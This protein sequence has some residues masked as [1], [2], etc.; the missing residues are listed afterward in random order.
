MPSSSMVDHLLQSLHTVFPSI[1]RLGLGH[2]VRSYLQ[3]SK[4]SLLEFLDD[5]PHARHRKDLDVH[6]CPPKL[7]AELVPPW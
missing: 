4:Q 1:L 5:A 2:D 6:E 7:Y 3:E